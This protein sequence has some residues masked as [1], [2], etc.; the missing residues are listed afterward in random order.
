MIKHRCKAEPLSSRKYIATNVKKQA[1]SA[2]LFA[3]SVENVMSCLVE[4]RT[5]IFVHSLKSLILAILIFAGTHSN[6]CDLFASVKTIT[7]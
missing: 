2:Q 4:K 1:S 5:T 6:C 7:V 3:S